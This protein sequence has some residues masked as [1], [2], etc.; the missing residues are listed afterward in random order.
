MCI[1]DSTW[2]HAYKHL[3]NFCIDNAHMCSD[4]FPEDDFECNLREELLNLKFR[5]HF[6]S[7]AVLHIK[8]S[9]VVFST[10]M[11]RSARP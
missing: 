1:R 11:G 2:I 4:H 3:D 8:I 6:K 9:S 5:K 7:T 10:N